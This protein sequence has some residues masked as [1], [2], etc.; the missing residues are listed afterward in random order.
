MKQ[1]E[2]S[3]Y[4]KLVMAYDRCEELPPVITSTGLTFPNLESLYEERY[5]PKNDQWPWFWTAIQRAPKLSIV[6]SRFSCS[7]LPFSQLTVW[8]IS[9]LDYH[10][11]INA[12]LEI[13]GNCRCLTALT[14]S[15][16][17]S[18]YG[19]SARAVELPSLRQ[20][21]ATAS[22]DWAGWLSTIAESLIM[23]SLEMCDI[24][25]ESW[26]PPPGLLILAERT[27]LSLKQLSLTLR[28]DSGEDPH[29][30]IPLFEVL[31]VTCELTKLELFLVETHQNHWPLID[32][33]ISKLL[34]KLEESSDRTRFLPRL[35]VLSLDVQHM[36]L[37]M[38][39]VEGILGAVSARQLKSHPLTDFCL[40]RRE[41][42]KGID[43]EQFVICPDALERI[44]TLEEESGIKVVI[45]D[46]RVAGI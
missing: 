30:N 44:R 2:S 6:T 43:D 26:D 20:F 46:R 3:R 23:P 31:Q 36:T 33:R 8:E 40:V 9:K 13:V 21:T 28:T 39:V 29:S 18:Y 17:V 15:A 7:K 11:E 27:S 12:F 37:N 5:I 19:V 25:Y 10:S 16:I 14:I 35:S 32:D 41:R 4:N 24:R 22:G 38:H 45:E 34:I 42:V 1:V